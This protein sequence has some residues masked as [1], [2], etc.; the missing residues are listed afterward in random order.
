M[1]IDELGIWPE[2][3]A[4]PYLGSAGASNKSALGN[5]TIG[6]D[7]TE[8][9]QF[10]VHFGSLGSSFTS[11]IRDLALWAK[12]GTGEALLSDESLEKR[13]MY[14]NPIKTLSKQ[15][16]CA[17]HLWPSPSPQPTNQPGGIFY[18]VTYSG[19]Y[20]HDGTASGFTSISIRNG[21]C[22]DRW[23]KGPN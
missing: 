14:K 21:L 10:Y 7:I 3:A 22:M 16:T 1:S 12:L 13:H 23:G 11:S 20:G 8:E 6:R 5:L 17:I 15:W 19:W 18:W 9:P 4:T 2:P